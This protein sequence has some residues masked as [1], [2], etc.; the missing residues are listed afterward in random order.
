MSKK[1]YEK[2]IMS[3]VMAN[4]SQNLL[5]DSCGNVP[6]E[7]YP[8]DPHGHHGGGHGGGHGRFRFF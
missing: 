2:P 4:Y 7:P 3:Q 1:I 6:E 5:A 8:R